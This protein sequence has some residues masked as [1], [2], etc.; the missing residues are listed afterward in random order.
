MLISFK[1]YCD[2]MEQAI[3]KTVAY[4][5]ANGYNGLLLD[6]G[7]MNEKARE[8]LAYEKALETLSDD[9]KAKM[10]YDDIVNIG[11]PIVDKMEDE[12]PD[13]Y[14]D[15]IDEELSDLI[16]IDATME[17]A[18]QCY[19]IFSEVQAEEFDDSKIEE[20]VKSNYAKGKDYLENIA[21]SN[22]E[23]YYEIVEDTYEYPNGLMLITYNDEKHED[24][25]EHICID[26]DNLQN[27]DER[28]LGPS[29]E[30]IADS[31]AK[32]LYSESAELSYG[33]LED[34]AKDIFDWY[35]AD[36]GTHFDDVQ[37]NE[38]V[39]YGDIMTILETK[40][41]EQIQHFIDD[42]TEADIDDD[43]AKK[44]K[45]ATTSSLVERLK[46]LLK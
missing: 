3:E 45:I 42:I 29:D 30:V 5:E 14:Y 15:A 24:E 44:I 8:D 16:Y 40:D 43:T 2:D 26:L 37:G 13:E 19:Y 25:K 33:D 7:E 9:N 31:K 6:V 46:A 27:L 1:V 21:K 11:K 17:G 18:K 39:V 41:Q 4:A 28:F 22:N 12:T 36:I 38:E 32:G 23:K 35:D 20:S 10:S 34:L